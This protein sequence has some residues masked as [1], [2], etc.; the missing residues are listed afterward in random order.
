[1]FSNNNNQNSN[2][3]GLFGNNNP[4]NN[5]PFGSNNPTTTPF[6]GGNNNNAAGGVSFSGM[7]F[8]SKH[9]MPKSGF[10]S[11]NNMQTN[12]KP[13]QFN[14]GGASNQNN[15]NTSGGFNT[16]TNP[17]GGGGTNKTFGSVDFT[18][19]P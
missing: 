14:Y 1:M 3:A 17:F 10:N 7:Q 12:I 8:N 4:T 15:Q 5:N 6:G 11:I 9:Q 18:S 13:P 16:N 2:S 19:V